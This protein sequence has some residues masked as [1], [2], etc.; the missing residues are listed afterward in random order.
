VG[1]VIDGTFDLTPIFLWI[2]FASF[3][4]FYSRKQNIICN[5]TGS[6]MRLF[7]RPYTRHRATTNHSPVSF[8]KVMRGN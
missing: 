2:S 5:R 7:V 4:I 6:H 8:L 1:I 3:I